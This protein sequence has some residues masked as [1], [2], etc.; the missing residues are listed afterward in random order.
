VDAET[1]GRVLCEANAAGVPVLASRC[2]GVESVVQCGGNGL[3]FEPKN[4]AAFLESLIRLRGDGELRRR[5]V[6]G[7]LEAAR[8]RF[9]WR[10]IVDRHQQVFE[11]MARRER[12]A[13]LEAHALGWERS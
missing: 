8:T 9:D 11:R 12:T 13:P 6:E 2:G 10:V 7:G 1:M 3:L 4:A 5:L